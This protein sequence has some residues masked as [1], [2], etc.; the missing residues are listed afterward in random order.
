MKVDVHGLNKNRLCWRLLTS[1]ARPVKEL[2]GFRR[3][4]LEQ[5]ETEKVTF[6]LA[7]EDLACYDAD[8]NFVVEQVVFNVMVGGSSEDI[9]LTRSFKV[10]N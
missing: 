4:T 9:R 10:Y 3:I 6:S 7:S 2:K 8:M 1:T 5:D